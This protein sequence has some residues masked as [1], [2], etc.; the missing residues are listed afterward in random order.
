[1]RATLRL[2]GFLLAT[3]ALIETA[4][5]CECGLPKE[6]EAAASHILSK[7]E[8][9]AFGRVLSAKQTARKRQQPGFLSDPLVEAR[10]EVTKVIKGRL[11][12]I[13]EVESEGYDNG[14]NCGFGTALLQMKRTG[15]VVG[16]ALERSKPQQNERFYVGG[17][18]AGTILDNLDR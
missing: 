10:I 16:F 3:G 5:A 15:R 13:I 7:A 12:K 2:L 14:A 11:P 4:Q 17:C 8:V 9:V 6:R 18:W 1:M